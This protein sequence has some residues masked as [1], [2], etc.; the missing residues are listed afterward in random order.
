MSDDL[1]ERLRARADQIVEVDCAVIEAG[2]EPNPQR[3]R[4]ERLLREA[5]N[6]LE[7]ERRANDALTDLTIIE[8]TT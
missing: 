7:R 3:A 4:D 5:A 2:G 6:A 1:V 8:A